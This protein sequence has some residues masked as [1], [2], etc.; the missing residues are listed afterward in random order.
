M[1]YGILVPQAGIKRTFPVLQGEFITTGPPG[2]ICYKIFN[3]LL[4]ITKGQGKE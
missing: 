3:D 4:L 2:K 1:A